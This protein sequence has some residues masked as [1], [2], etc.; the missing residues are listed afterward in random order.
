VHYYEKYFSIHH[1]INWFLIWCLTCCPNNGCGS[2]CWLLLLLH[3]VMEKVLK[4]L[5]CCR[6]FGGA[7][8][9]RKGYELVAREK[10]SRRSL[11]RSCGGSHLVDSGSHLLLCS[12]CKVIL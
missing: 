1:L 12:E 9:R 7:N 4:L 10:L 11:L 6:S 2:P 3:L 8:R 5:A